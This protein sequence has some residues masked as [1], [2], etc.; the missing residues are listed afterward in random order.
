MHCR[1]GQCCVRVVQKGAR[2]VKFYMYLC[3]IIYVYMC[4]Y[5]IYAAGLDS[6]EF[7]WCR[8]E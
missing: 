6:A 8:R 2:A 5:A 1:T 4:I 3:E 7:G